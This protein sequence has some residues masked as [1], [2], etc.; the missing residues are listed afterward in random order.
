[1]DEALEHV[2]ALLKPRLRAFLQEAIGGAWDRSTITLMCIT[3]P[4]L[5]AHTSQMSQ[6]STSFVISDKSKVSFELDESAFAQYQVLDP[7]AHRVVE[8]LSALLQPVAARIA[9]GDA[10]EDP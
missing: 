9:G 7:Y 2:V 4:Q 10:S 3:I 8:F 1:V 6:P 5:G